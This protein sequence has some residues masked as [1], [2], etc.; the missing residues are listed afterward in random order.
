M[1]PRR[2]STTTRRCRIGRTK[3]IPCQDVQTL[4]HES[5]LDTH[6]KIRVLFDPTQIRGFWWR[7]FPVV[8]LFYSKIKFQEKKI[9]NDTN[10]RAR[11]LDWRW[12]G[13]I[14]R[15]LIYTVVPRV[16]YI[17]TLMYKWINDTLHC[18]YVYRIHTHTHT[19]T[20]VGDILRLAVRIYF[21]RPL[22]C[23]H[24]KGTRI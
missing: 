21:C 3:M 12:E 10:A 6:A 13:S 14:Y 18:V 23:V 15:T 9:N 1:T 19:Q 4:Q 17:N 22:K 11:M 2:P 5:N 20:Q 7:G 24:I 8:R 16:K